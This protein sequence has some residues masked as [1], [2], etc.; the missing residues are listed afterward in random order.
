MDLIF[1][2]FSDVAL[3][4]VYSKH[5]KT[6]ELTEIDLINADILLN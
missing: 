5:M 2:S 4:V 3:Y 1:R 6:A